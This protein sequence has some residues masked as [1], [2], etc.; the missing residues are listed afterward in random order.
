MKANV[1]VTFLLWRDNMVKAIYK[2][3]L[4]AHVQFQSMS[5]WPS[6]WGTWEQAGR[7]GAGVAGESF[8]MRLQTPADRKP[9]GRV[10]D[11][12]TSKPI[13]SDHKATSSIPSETFYQVGTKHP[14]IWAHGDHS[15]L[16]HQSWETPLFFF[17]RILYLCMLAYMCSCPA[18]PDKDIESPGT[19]VTDNH[20]LVLCKSRKLS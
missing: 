20:P 11:F 15:H 4:G 9:S 8:M 17:L 2:N 14:N 19:R 12:E 6:W 5:P 3:C 10:W 7:H 13:C 16:N 1:L 18:R